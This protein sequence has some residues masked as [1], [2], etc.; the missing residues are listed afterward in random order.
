MLSQ[1]VGVRRTDSKNNFPNFSRVLSEY[2]LRGSR[3]LR[4]LN[5]AISFKMH[6]YSV[7]ESTAKLSMPLSLLTQDRHL[8][9]V[10]STS[11]ELYGRQMNVKTMLFVCYENVTDLWL[12]NTVS[13]HDFCLLIV[14]I[15]KSFKLSLYIVYLVYSISIIIH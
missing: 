6:L 15:L 13:F 12:I 3:P 4:N 2:R 9:V 14:R 7:R 5:A 1:Y 11:F 10:D 8:D